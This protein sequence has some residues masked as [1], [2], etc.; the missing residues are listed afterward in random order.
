M[1]TL[2]R[3]KPIGAKRAHTCDA[4]CYNASGNE[5]HCFCKG[6]NHG[7][8]F[9]TAVNNTIKDKALYQSMGAT[10]AQAIEIAVKE[11]NNASY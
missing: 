3:L 5:C 6:A 8:G 9:E 7:K 2:L 4:R 1:A 11:L 10:L